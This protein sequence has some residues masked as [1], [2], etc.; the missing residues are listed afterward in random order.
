M[1]YIATITEADQ[2]QETEQILKPFKRQSFAPEQKPALS[3]EEISQ[4]LKNPWV[5]KLLENY[6]SGDLGKN[7][8]L[9]T[10]GMAPEELKKAQEQKAQAALFLKKIGV[11]KP[12]IKRTS[13]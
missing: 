4:E 12:S 6:L 11:E 10:R 1:I 13:A 3:A 7:T 5:A 9:I 8:I 2:A